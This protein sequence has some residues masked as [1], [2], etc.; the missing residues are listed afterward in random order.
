MGKYKFADIFKQLKEYNYSDIF[1]PSKKSAKMFLVC[2]SI[3]LAIDFLVDIIFH[4]ESFKWGEYFLWDLISAA[5]LTII[6]FISWLLAYRTNIFPKTKI[7]EGIHG[8]SFF[9]LIIFIPTL[10]VIFL[11]IFD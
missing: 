6:Y 10:I 8:C 2:M 1:S 4:K 9:F 5:G 11:L 3:F 7:R